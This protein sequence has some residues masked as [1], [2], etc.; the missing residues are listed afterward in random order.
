MTPLAHIQIAFFDFGAGKLF[1]IV[2]FHASEAF[3]G[4]CE[5]YRQVAMGGPLFSYGAG[6]AGSCHS[7]VR[8]IFP[9]HRK[10]C[11]LGLGWADTHLGHL[12]I[13]LAEL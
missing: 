8:K 13:F 2:D 1:L 3:G 6:A 9:A 12:V 11:R 4:F 5:L 7:G 10:E